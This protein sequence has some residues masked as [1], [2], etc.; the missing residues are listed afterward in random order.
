VLRY[1]QLP[2]LVCAALVL[3]VGLTI[4]AC[5]KSKIT[6]ANFD[7]IQNDMDLA[8]VERILGD[9]KPQD[10]GDGAVMLGQ[11]GVAPLD[12]GSSGSKTATY[13]WEDGKKKIT[14]Y[15]RN[16]KVTKKEPT[17]L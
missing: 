17:G 9:G 16:G 7:R 15:F 3:A 12:A 2:R 14:V 13:V 5:G 6:Q 10:G 8:Q 1:R 4:P 11:V